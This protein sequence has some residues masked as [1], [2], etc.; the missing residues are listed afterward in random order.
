ML[1][2]T[3]EARDIIRMIPEERRY[4]DTA[5]LRIARPEEAPRGFR[6]GPVNAPAED[7]HV[8]ILDGAR[9]FLDPAAAAHL[10][11]K[12]LDARFDS[13]GRVHF[14]ATGS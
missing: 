2:M 5:G 14:H 12:Q 11:G 10:A 9:V 1:T 13:Q 6:V 4:A 7:D 8:V 3:D